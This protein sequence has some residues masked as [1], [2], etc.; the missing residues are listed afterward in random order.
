MKK[1]IYLARQEAKDT[2]CCINA[3]KML[4]GLAAPDIKRYNAI[5]LAVMI[6]WTNDKGWVCM[7]NT[8]R[9]TLLHKNICIPKKKKNTEHWI[10]MN[11]LETFL[12]YGMPF[13]GTKNG[14]IIPH[15]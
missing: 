5:I 7:E 13:I 11:G 1:N 14:N 3:D 9:E 15:F 10:H 8:W 6:E 12:K 4:G 2:V